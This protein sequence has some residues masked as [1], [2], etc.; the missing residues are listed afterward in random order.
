MSVDLSKLHVARI[1]A[2][3]LFKIT[4]TGTGR[5]PKMLEGRFTSEGR[6]LDQL[7]L[8]HQ[9]TYPSAYIDA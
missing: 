4:R 3:N 8:W 2:S 5:I 6:A 7:K 9:S 1:G